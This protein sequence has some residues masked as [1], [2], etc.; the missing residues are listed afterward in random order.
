[1]NT[2][3]DNNNELKTLVK[4]KYNLIAIEDWGNKNIWNLV[5]DTYPAE[6]FPKIQKLWFNYVDSDPFSH[7]S[8]VENFITFNNFLFKALYEYEQNFIG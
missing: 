3:M 7:S 6:I 8:Y 1:M 5:H 2:K 4:L